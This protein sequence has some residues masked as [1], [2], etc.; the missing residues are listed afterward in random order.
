MS[1]RQMTPTP[2]MTKT[3]PDADETSPHFGVAGTRI[4]GRI[5]QRWR[6]HFGRRPKPLRTS[7]TESATGSLR[8]HL[9]P[10]RQ[11]LE[12]CSERGSIAGRTPSFADAKKEP[13]GGTGSFL[14]SDQRGS[15]GGFRTPR[16]LLSMRAADPSVQQF[17]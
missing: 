8:T 1:R 3:L 13:A 9:S 5:G 12:L 15:G 11:R 17:Q 6:A 14:H 7:S 4:P 10:D 2:V 16:S